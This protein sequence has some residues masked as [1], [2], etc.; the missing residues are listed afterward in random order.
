[1]SQF[2]FLWSILYIFLMPFTASAQSWQAVY[3]STLYNY[4]S[5]VNFTSPSKGV[6]VGFNGQ[7]IITE[8]AGNTWQQLTPFTSLGFTDVEFPTPDTGFVCGGSGALY[9]TVDGGYTWESQIF[10]TSN[11]FNELF[12]LNKDTGFVISYNPTNSYISYIHKTVNAGATWFQ[13]GPI[14][15]T[16]TQ[17]DVCFI[18]DSIGF[19]ASMGGSKLFRT[20]NGGINWTTQWVGST[21]G[22]LSIKFVNDSTG[23]LCGH[24]GLLYKTTDKGNSWNQ[25]NPG[26][27][28]DLRE[29]FFIDENTGWVSGYSSSDVFITYDGGQTWSASTLPVVNAYMV[30][31]SQMIT[32]VYGYVISMVTGNGSTIYRFGE[33]I[34]PLNHNAIHGRIFSDQNSNCIFDSNDIPMKNKILVATPGN[35]YSF[36]N[37]SGFYT[38][39]LTPGT[40]QINQ[41]IQNNDALLINQNC[42]SSPGYHTVVFDDVN[43]DTLGLDFSN[44]VIEC[45]NLTVDISSNR[46]RRCFQN[47]TNVR[48]CN[49]GYASASNVDVFVQFPEYVNFI[50]ADHPYTT[51]INGNYV[52][53]IGNLTQGE[54]GNIYII[55][56][57]SC[58]AGIVGL[59]QCTK[60]WITPKNDCVES[61]DT[62]IS[63]WD[64]SSISVEGDCIGDTIVHFVITN[65]GDFGVGD[66]QIPSEYRIYADNVFIFSGTFQLNGGD[67]LIVDR[68]SNG[69]TIRLEADQHP[70]HPGHSHPQ[71]TI[72]ACGRN[73]FA[74]SLGFVNTL[75]MDDENV[76]IEIDCMEIRD[77][78]DPNYKSVSPQGITEN[79]YILPNT[80]LDYVIHFQNTGSDTAYTVVIIDTLSEHLNI[81]T[82]EWGISSHP[83]TVDVSGQNKPILSFT[84]TNINLPD[85][86]IDEA[87]SNGFV[88]FKISPYDTLVNGTEIEN[89]ADIYFDFNLPIRTN[90]A[91]VNI[92]DTLLMTSYNEVSIKNGLDF[93]KVMPNPFDEYFLIVF[94]N[95]STYE[96]KVSDILGNTILTSTYTGLRKTISTSELKNG[97]Y[98]LQ[99]KSDDGIQIEKLIKK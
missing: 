50:S 66:M 13:L 26:T 35:Y 84:F 95:H 98:I 19:I 77:S 69:Q 90:P 47:N 23:Y 5:D 11:N 8:D 78:Y 99:V 30:Y 16:N 63:A 27:T 43:Q 80:M 7:V 61:L 14:G 31:A 82:I 38:M 28:I 96:I 93:F 60:A 24:G 71:E 2:V 58:D 25:L 37:D 56:S 18:N 65:T 68:N 3:S 40:F 86:T 6:A 22:I 42:P 17:W 73:S 49:L 12:F 92:F 79:N 53:H 52:F 1:M 55:D 59:T 91:H 57:V 45:S 81:S 88:K 20:I 15:S 76:D 72:E 67:S 39:H 33:Y 41:I 36:T 97:V 34:E 62:T 44:H 32:P 10:L 9:R 46:R 70:L 75:P 74:V 21:A 94:K 51:D 89:I 54:C 4:I 29:L 48:Y 87:N 85:S 83:Y 64:K